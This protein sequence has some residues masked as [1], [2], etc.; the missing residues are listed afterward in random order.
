MKLYASMFSLL[1]LLLVSCGPSTKLEKTWADPSF[2]KAN[3]KPFKKVL[4]VGQLDNESNRRIAEDKMAAQFAPGV[5]FQSYTYLT[6]GDTDRAKVASKLK[7]EGFE[8][9]IIMHLDKVDESVSYVQGSGG[10][11]GG[12]YGGWYGYH[13]GSQGYHQEDKAYSVETNIFSLETDKLLWSGTTK[14]MNPSSVS[15]TLDEIIQAI[16]WHLVLMAILRKI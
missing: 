7:G 15:K 8:A 2:T 4:V 10:Y 16:K 5:G 13:G 9:V 1:I 3:A 14:T 12:Y 6:A 11:Y